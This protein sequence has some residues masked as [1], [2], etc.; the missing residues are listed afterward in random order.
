MIYAPPVVLHIG[1]TIVS[2]LLFLLK[3]RQAR[4]VVVT[5]LHSD[6]PQGIQSVSFQTEFSLRV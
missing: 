6:I 5:G 2:S 4:Q 3:M 1:C